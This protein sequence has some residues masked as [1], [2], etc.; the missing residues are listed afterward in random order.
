MILRSI[1]GDIFKVKHT[2]DRHW[3]HPSC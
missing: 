3:V 2:V 1:P